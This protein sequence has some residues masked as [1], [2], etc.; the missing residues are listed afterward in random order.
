MDYNTEDRVHDDLVIFHEAWENLT[1]AQMAARRARRE[2]YR[3]GAILFGEEN[4]IPLVTQQDVQFVH[5]W[6]PRFGWTGVPFY[7][8]T[9]N[10]NVVDNQPQNVIA[11]HCVN[12][13]LNLWVQGGDLEEGIQRAHDRFQQFENAWDAYHNAVQ[14][15]QQ[16]QKA[17]DHAAA[18]LVKAT[19]IPVVNQN[20]LQLVRALRDEFAWFGN[21]KYPESTNILHFYGVLTPAETREDEE[22]LTRVATNMRFCT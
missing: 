11:Q 13:G 4:R 21:A 3:L 10:I 22:R 12:H 2:L 9:N 6:G 18:V 17:Y 7:P 20:Q 5:E 1:V 16:P 8:V 14:A 19:I 15:I